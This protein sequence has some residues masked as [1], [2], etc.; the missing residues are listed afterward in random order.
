MNLINKRK[1]TKQQAIDAIA[2]EKPAL[3]LTVGA[4]DI[5]QLVEPLKIALS[6]V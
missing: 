5:D 6:N 3:L 4:G 2:N 1:L